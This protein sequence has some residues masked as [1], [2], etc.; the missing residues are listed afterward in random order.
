[1]K[2]ETTDYI[3][4][5][6]DQPRP[7][8]MCRNERPGVCVKSKVADGHSQPLVNLCHSCIA[9][10]GNFVMSV[11]TVDSFDLYDKPPDLPDLPTAE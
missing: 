10:I 8:A 11:D 6:H 4:M 1:M 9:V 3:L 2:L 7:C 5:S